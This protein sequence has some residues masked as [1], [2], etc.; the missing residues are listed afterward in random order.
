MALVAHMSFLSFL[1][2]WEK[3][4]DIIDVDKV[5]CEEV[6][7]L[8][9]FVPGCLCGETGGTVEISNCWFNAGD[10]KDVVERLHCTWAD[11]VENFNV[12]KYFSS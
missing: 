1:L 2:L 12:G 11:E 7:H 8:D 5:P 9:A 4:V 3:N 6:A 10:I